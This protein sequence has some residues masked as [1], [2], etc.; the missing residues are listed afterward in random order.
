[1]DAESFLR[2]GQEHEVFGGVPRWEMLSKIPMKCNSVL[3][4]LPQFPHEYTVTLWDL[5]RPIPD[6]V[7]RFACRPPADSYDRHETHEQFP[8]NKNGT[9]VTKSNLFLFP[10]ALSSFTAH[11]ASRCR[12]LAQGTSGQNSWCKRA[13]QTAGLLSPRME[14]PE[15]RLCLRLRLRL[16]LR[17]PAE[18]RP[19]PAAL[20]PVK[21]P[22][23]APALQR[24]LSSVQFTR[25]V[26]SDSL[27]PHEPQHARPPGVTN[28][29]SPPKPC[30]LRQ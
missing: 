26:V 18:P 21:Q 16:R 11:V 22:R 28:S 29:R 10:C 23:R 24:D 3:L 13:T 9:W 19:L 5:S 17:L 8:G 6:T 14:A 27:R 2:H 20:V 25:S 12:A 15:V 1:M 30:P 4:L 7:I